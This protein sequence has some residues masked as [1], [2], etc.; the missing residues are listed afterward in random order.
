[1]AGVLPSISDI[2]CEVPELR[3]DNFKIWKERILL[4]LG[5]MDI[6]YA[7]RKDEPHK[8]TD[9]S[10]PEQILL[11]ERWEKSN[12]LSVMYIKTKI[13]A[14]IRGSIEQHENVRELL[15]AIDEQFV[16]SDKALAST[17]IMKFTSLKLTAIRGVRE[18]IMEM[19]D[20]VAQLKK[21]E[22]EMSE[23]F[24]VHFILNTLPPQNEATFVEEIASFIFHEK[25]N[26]AQSDIAEDLVGIDSRLCE[27]EPLLCLKAADVRIIGIWGMSGIGKTT[28]AGAIFERFRNQFEGCVFFENV[29]T[30]LEREG[31]EGL[32]EKLLPKILGLKNLSLT[33]RP[34]IKAALGSKKVLIVLDNVKDPMI[35][36]K[37]AKKRDWFGVGSRIIITTTNKNVLRTHEVKEIYEVK[38]FDGDEAMKIFSRYAFKQDHPRK[39]FVELSK[40]IIACTHGLPLAIKLLGD[41]LFEKSKHEWETK[42]D[43]LN[44]DL[45]LGINCL[46]MSYNELNDDE[47]CLFL[48]IACFFKGENIDY[49]A[50]ILDNHN[51]CPIDGIHALVDKSLITISGNKLQ[52]HDLLQEMG[53]E[54]VCQKSQEPGKRTRLWKHEDISLVLKNNKGTEEVEGI[55]LDLSHVKE[56]LHFKTPAFARMNKLKL[57]KVYNSGGASKK[58][59]L[60]LLTSLGG[61]K[62][63]GGMRPTE[64]NLFLDVIHGSPR[65]IFCELNDLHS[66]EVGFFCNAFNWDGVMRGIVLVEVGGLVKEQGEKSSCKGT[67]SSSI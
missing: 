31:I 37:I 45:K 16:T 15:K 5:C 42:L 41:L 35:I 52:M 21:L 13:S 56:K 53:R 32:Q 57:L 8:I 40:S 59:N 61:L 3:G 30:Q 2:R 47:Q 64:F 28:L 19:R 58:G 26:M 54:V 10:T 38:K 39:D 46:Q 18:H 25:I 12:R 55:S 4:Q 60:V 33:G 63:L 29:G 14:G 36:E 9:T 48:D 51:C 11:Y 17:L 27:I 1:M 22:V 20:I 62:M 66:L 34:S 67:R 24:L 65:D 44:K 43:K 49:V 50:K 7:I 6:D 23:S